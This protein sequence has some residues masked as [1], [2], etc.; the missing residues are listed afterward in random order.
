M[1]VSLIVAV[2][3]NGVIGQK[4]RLPWKLPAD[5]KRFKALTM[6]H[7]IVMG[8]KTYESIGKALPGRTNIVV[9]RQAGYR[10][11]GCLVVD[12]LEHGLALARSD[13]EIFVIGGV[14][15]F[16][17]AIPLANR[18]YLTQI[19]QDFEGDARLPALDRTVWHETAREDHP[20][21]PETPL[22]YSFLTLERR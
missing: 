2:A 5:L 20:S 3:R 22:A 8:R 6:G 19:D 17:Q 13:E 14:E 11:E 7:P 10:A 1:R 16:T 12:S 9:T 18:I 4:N 21:G 15:I